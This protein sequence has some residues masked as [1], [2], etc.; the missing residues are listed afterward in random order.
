M[1][2]RRIH[3]FELI[4]Y[5]ANKA[6]PDKNG[7]LDILSHMVNVDFMLGQRCRQ[8]TYINPALPTL[9]RKQDRSTPIQCFLNFGPALQTMDQE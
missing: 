8:L 1:F 9:Q 6:T 2:C 7:V 5:Q 4:L 3:E